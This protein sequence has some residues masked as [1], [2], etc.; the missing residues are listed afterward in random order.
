LYAGPVQGFGSVIVN[1]V[2]FSSVGSALVDDDGNSVNLRD[3][4]LGMTVLIS[5]T[6][7]DSTGLGSATQVELVHGTRGTITAIDT[8]A[9]TITLLGQTIKTDTTT[10]FQGVAN[11]AALSVGQTVEI[12]GAQQADG[13]V[14]ATLVEVK[15][16][17][18]ISLSGVVANLNTG[19]NSFQIGTLTVNYPA[20]AV[21]GT[22]VN[23]ARVKVRAASG[24]LSGNVLTATSVRVLGSG[25]ALGTTAPA[26][27]LLKIKGIAAAAPVNGVLT[28]SGTPIDISKATLI[29]GTSITAG[30]VLEVKGTW[31]G[32]TLQATK[33][34]FEGAREARIGGRNEL[35]GVVSSISGSIAVVNGVSVDLSAAVFSHGSASQVV[36]GSYLE[37]Q[38]DVVGN[39][40]MA[41]RVELKIG[42]AANGMA[43]EQ[44]G[45]VS[46]FVSLSNFKL[47][48]LTVDASKATLES[49]SGSTTIANGSYIE[50]T[51]K[52]DAN[53]VFVATKIE[54]K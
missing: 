37:I 1:G 43:F 11:L 14:L 41:N 47:G 46:G 38:G 30:S 27:A 29:G 7:D 6:A 9:K 50:I 10:V 44:S 23:G 2:R 24:G 48:G 26:G 3:L 32:S 40:L 12:F 42:A 4:K 13:S 52:L 53:N 33:V 39:T 8:T 54:L 22:L 31:D 45:T 16:I 34:E 17:T 19:A 28:L 51:G 21:N 20:N 18:A 49:K 15:S 35:Y 36:V 25:F 5:G